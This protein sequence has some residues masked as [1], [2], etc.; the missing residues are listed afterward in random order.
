MSI[1]ETT[2]QKKSREKFTNKIKEIQK[3]AYGAILTA[4][5]IRIGDLN[6]PENKPLRSQILRASND[7]IRQLE[8][9]LERS[10]TIEYEATTEDVIVVQPP[11]RK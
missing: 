10:Y 3:K 9:E 2:N 11:L 8:K 1:E 5:E 4:V 6:S 7:A